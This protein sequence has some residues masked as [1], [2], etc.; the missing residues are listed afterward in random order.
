MTPTPHVVCSGMFAC[1]TQPY[2]AI[3]T[4]LLVVL[5]AAIVVVVLHGTGQN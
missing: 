3:T 4:L 1:G 5:T 2:L